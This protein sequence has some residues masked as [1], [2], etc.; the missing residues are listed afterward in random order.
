M[1][2]NTD[3]YIDNY[4]NWSFKAAAAWNR[5]T[6]KSL[7]LALTH[8]CWEKSNTLDLSPKVKD[9]FSITLSTQNKTHKEIYT[10][11]RGSEI[12]F[13]T[14]FNLTSAAGISFGY[15]QGKTFSLGL[16]Y[17]LGLKISF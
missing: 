17:E 9:S 10:Y 5:K 2:I 6:N 4:I 14:N 11:S 16:N 12:T 7:L 1:N 13:L 15:E 8:L 3:F